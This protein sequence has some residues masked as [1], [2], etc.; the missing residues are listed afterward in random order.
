M[1]ILL[2]TLKQTWLMIVLT[3]ICLACL[4]MLTYYCLVTSNMLLAIVLIALK[5]IVAL[6]TFI[7]ISDL[8]YQ[9]K[10]QKGL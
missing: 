6:T 9:L 4:S 10:N 7:I 5:C 2:T 8:H 3:S 1:D